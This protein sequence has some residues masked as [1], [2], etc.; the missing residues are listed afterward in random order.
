[1]ATVISD[2]CQASPVQFRGAEW[3]GPGWKAWRVAQGTGAEAQACSGW[4][5]EP[6]T[7]S[8][9]CLQGHCRW[10]R[11]R[12]WYLICLHGKA[13]HPRGVGRARGLGTPPHLSQRVCTCT[14]P[15]S[16]ALP[17]LPPSPPAPGARGL[18]VALLAPR[19]GF[20]P[21]RGG[22]PWAWGSPSLG[23]SVPGP[24]LVLYAPTRVGG[25]GVP[26]GGTGWVR[27]PLG[28]HVTCCALSPTNVYPGAEAPRDTHD[29]S[30][31]LPRPGS[32]VTRGQVPQAPSRAEGRAAGQCSVLRPVGLGPSGSQRGA[33]QALWS[34]PHQ[35]AGS[36]PFVLL[37]CG[38]H[39]L[40]RSPRARGRAG[41]CRA[42]SRF[43]PGG[44][45]QQ[46]RV[47]CL[48]LQVG[49]RRAPLPRRSAA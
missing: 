21:W 8:I 49:R 32:S 29:S 47:L 48:H 14:P 20:S 18:S 22:K 37:G 3:S 45:Q 12:L 35:T 2:G 11:L 17:R 23:P 46:S 36:K 19:A 28:A 13:P 1:M 40:L 27:D 24:L 15:P 44:G 34:P 30:R 43:S 9:R 33:L 39:R 10:S 7:S 41:P 4:E 5:G 31:H 42:P 26:A 6:G 38:E 25:E 16:R